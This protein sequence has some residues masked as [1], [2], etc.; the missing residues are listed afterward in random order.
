MK[1]LI[2]YKSVSII[3]ME[4]NTGKTTTLNFLL[5]ALKGKTVGLTSI[6]RDGE[7]TDIVTQ[8]EKPTIYVDKGTI[9][10]TAKSS[11]LKSD[12][13]F[14]I[15]AV[16]EINTPM[17]VV[18][19]ARAISD[20][21]IE[22]A[23]PSTKMKVKEAIEQIT[24][25]G[26]DIVL[27]DGALSRK[28]FADPS[29][30]QGCVLC[31]GAAYKEDCR[32]LCEE[33][34]HFVKLLT[35]DEAAEKV[36][37]AYKESMNTAKIVFIYKHTTIVSGVKTSIGAAKEVIENLTEGLK[38]I[39]INGIITD[40]FIKEI[41]ASGKVLKGICFIVENGTKL[42]LGSENYY[43]FLDKG[44]KIEVINNINI[45]GISVNPTSPSGIILDYSK[46][47]SELK[48][49]TNLL[50]FNVRRMECE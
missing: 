11:L 3:G 10:A 47:E 40:S 30:T 28:S 33:T 12:A 4:K 37:K 25:F 38:Y 23:G 5:K 21:Y 43:R 39:F 34:A 15:L 50:V 20:G 9:V 2:Q 27:A 22:I 17:G 14:E 1:K 16:S 45:I 32:S 19:Y 41:L 36:K 31:T 7:D 29:V 46:I 26:A 48:K 35:L 24:A 13:T 42:F 8:T 6:G 44:G 18:V 49:R